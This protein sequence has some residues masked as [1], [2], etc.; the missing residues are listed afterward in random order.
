MEK[1]PSDQYGI[2]IFGAMGWSDPGG[3]F[4]SSNT[5][6]SI[7]YRGRVYTISSLIDDNELKEFSNIIT[8][9]DISGLMLA[10]FNDLG[11]AIDN[12]IDFLC[13]KKDALDKLDISDIEK[14]KKSFDTI[15]SIVKFVSETSKQILLD[16][17][18]DKNLIKTDTS[19]LRSHLYK[20][21]DQIKEKVVEAPL[22]EIRQ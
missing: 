16:Y 18:N 8:I 9:G 19:K 14:L 10:T 11:G 5:N 15:L 17:Q 13:S 7:R 6:R 22:V 4:L 2:L 3:E 1:E 12:S 20:L 21:Y